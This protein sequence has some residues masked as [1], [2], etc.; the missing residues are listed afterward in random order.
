MML[1]YMLPTDILKY[2]ENDHIS[3]ILAWTNLYKKQ[4]NRSDDCWKSL[5]ALWL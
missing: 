1:L 3:R 2:R 5:A 4:R